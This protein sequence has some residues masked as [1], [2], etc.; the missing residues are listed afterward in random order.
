MNGECY[1]VILLMLTLV[2]AVYNCFD[3]IETL[4]QQAVSALQDIVLFIM[5]FGSIFWMF[6]SLY[7]K[8]FGDLINGALWTIVATITII[9]VH[10]LENH[11]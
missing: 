9:T 5:F 2:D 6:F 3:M 4:L 8:D 10:S 11:S 7:R 1:I